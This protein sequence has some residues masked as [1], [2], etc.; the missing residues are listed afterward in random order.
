MTLSALLDHPDAA[1]M[2]GTNLQFELKVLLS[3]PL[4]YNLRNSYCHGLVT[5]QGLET[6][7]VVNLWWT[8][9]RILL[10]PWAPSYLEQARARGGV[11]R[12]RAA[13][14]PGPQPAPP[15]VE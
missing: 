10:W 9:W 15:S 6:T 14:E 11:P 12:A 2:F 7:G 4:G 8:L 1:R 3:E 13:G 5:D